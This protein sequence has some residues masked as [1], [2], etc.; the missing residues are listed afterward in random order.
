MKRIFRIAMTIVIL[1]S[2]NSVFLVNEVMAVNL[3]K[4]IIKIGYVKNNAMFDEDGVTG[5][6]GFGYE[7][8]KEIAKYTGQE[9]E[10]V[11]V[12][13]ANGLELLEKG[14]IDIFG[15]AIK[16][17]EREKLY[18]Y[19]PTEVIY[20]NAVLCALKEDDYNFGEPESLN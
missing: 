4:D 14:E 12:N 20:D 5:S 3:N 17:P 15:P 2:I 16:T 13:W 1:L 6:K 9:Y 19:I 10:F 11:K 8:F 7:Y 18:E